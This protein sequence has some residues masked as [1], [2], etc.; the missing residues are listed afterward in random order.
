M[1]GLIPIMLNINNK[2]ILVIGGGNVA[3][4]KAA[5]FIKNGADVTV[6]A[7][8]FVPKF[9]STKAHL[10]KS[11]VMEMEGIESLISESLLIIA[12]TGNR[13][14]NDY[15]E[16]LCT[17]A[18]KLCNVVD[19]QE[20]QVMF[21]AFFRKGDIVVAVSTCGNVPYFSAYLKKVAMSELSS[22]LKAY[23]TIKAIRKSIMGIN[24]KARKRIL[25]EIIHDEGF[26]KMINNKDKRGAMKIADNIIKKRTSKLF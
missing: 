8:E 25:N 20:T 4:R 21:P 2:K 23:S 24:V 15:I 16:K 22:Y 11:D 19:K 14:I 17:A 26:W 12:A 10:I 7:Q 5:M 3:Y 1:S 13:K 9:K 18:G 6:I